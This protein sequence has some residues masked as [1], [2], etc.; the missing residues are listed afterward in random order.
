[1]EY[2]TMGPGTACLLLFLIFF[3]L[4]FL[5][6]LGQVKRDDDPRPGSS[7]A[8]PSSRKDQAGRF[9]P[10]GRIICRGFYLWSLVPQ[11]LEEIAFSQASKCL[12][13]SHWDGREYADGDS[14]YLA[15]M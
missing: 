9:I 3:T 13:L 12:L 15:C 1:M 7:Y 11:L 10:Q 8:G 6:I 2:I 14:K 5:F 4:T